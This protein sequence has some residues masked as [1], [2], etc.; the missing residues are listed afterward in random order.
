MAFP[1]RRR[2]RPTQG[3]FEGDILTILTY[4]S[5]QG[6]R[7]ISLVELSSALK[8]PLRSIRRIFWY[9]A[10]SDRDCFRFIAGHYGF[11]YRI[12]RH[13]KYVHPS[14]LQLSAF[15]YEVSCVWRGYDPEAYPEPPVMDPT[16]AEGAA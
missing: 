1:R 9:A 8:I 12:R 14:P 10:R 7:W 4:C 3:C 2:G 11:V 15:R 13:Q 16:V 5:R 6:G